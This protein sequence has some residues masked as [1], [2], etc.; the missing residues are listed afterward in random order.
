[1]QGGTGASA[2]I[3]PWPAAGKTGS[4]QDNVDAWFCGYTV[5]LS[6]CVWVGYPEE[7]RPL[8]NIAGVPVVYGG[9]IPAAIWHDYMLEA[10][11]YGA[12]EWGWV[13]TAFSTDWSLDGHRGGSHADRIARAAEPLT[14]RGTL[15]RAERADARAR[16]P[17]TERRPESDRRPEP[18]RRSAA[19]TLS[20]A[21]RLS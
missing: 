19:D 4:A 21:R 16:T 5:Q 2:S 3:Y 14:E 13:P 20:R 12:G 7:Q 17:I 9:T 15:T 11:A 10:M 1:M 8:I 18:D 6:T